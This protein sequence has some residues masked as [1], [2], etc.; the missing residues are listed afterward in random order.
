MRYDAN[1]VAKFLE[2]EV[3]IKLRKRV[4]AEVEETLFEIL[5]NGTYVQA[6]GAIY[7]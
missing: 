2:S 3:L 5:V 4:F 6:V 1:A 7:S